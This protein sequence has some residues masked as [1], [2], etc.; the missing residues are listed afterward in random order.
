MDVFNASCRNKDS[1]LFELPERID[2]MTDDERASLEGK[3]LRG[4]QY[5][6]GCPERNDCLSE[7]TELDLEVT[8]RGGQ[9]PSGFKFGVRRGKFTPIVKRGASNSG[10]QVNMEGEF[11][12]EFLSYPDVRGKYEC[13]NGHPVSMEALANSGLTE[14]M[15]K[16]TGT[17]PEGR[18]LLCK[19]TIMSRYSKKK[20]RGTLVLVSS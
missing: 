3:L 15:K 17:D 2:T 4:Q 19:K 14:G 6:F 12:E 1:S 11:L 10:G 20:N 9:L 16:R 18:C 7:A 13:D 5:C 8:T